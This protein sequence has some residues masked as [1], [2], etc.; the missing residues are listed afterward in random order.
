[1]TTDLLAGIT[2]LDFGT[3]GPAARASAILADYGAQ[4]TK[5][6]AVPRSGTVAITPPAFAYS[7]GRGTRRVQLDLKSDRGRAAAQR[8]RR[9]ACAAAGS[10]NHQQPG[11]QPDSET[12]ACQPSQ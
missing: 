5:V 4:V 12:G 11:S 3:V 7:G 10:L 9:R 6:G 1:M 8:I 2:V